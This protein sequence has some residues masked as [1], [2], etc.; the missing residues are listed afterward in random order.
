MLFRSDKDSFLDVETNTSIENS[1]WT[2]HLRANNYFTLLNDKSLYADVTYTYLSPSIQGNAT[3]ESYSKLGLNFRKTFWNKDASISMGV[4]D[5][6]NNGNMFSTRDYL[7][8]N[9][10]TS[11]RKETRLFVFGFRYKFGNTK[12]RDNYKRK[13]TEEGKRL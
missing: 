1:I 3:Y 7:D 11:T 4:D 8:Q 10:I 5:I 13:N 6:F 9:N 2:T 12:I